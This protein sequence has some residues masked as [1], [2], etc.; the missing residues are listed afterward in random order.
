MV[1]KFLLGMV[2]GGLVVAGGL[3]VASAVAPMRPAND[4]PPVP[5]AEAQVAPAA[6]PADAAV[7]V[8]VAEA[9]AEPAPAA[10]AESVAADLPA[11]QPDVQP[12]IAGAVDGPTAP[13]LAMG[14]GSLST[15]PAT[16][17]SRS[18]SARIS[19]EST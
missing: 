13:M 7:A 9:Q 10:P 8:A 15:R 18:R 1:G 17:T 5:G 4:T 2:S 3:I 11:V 6:E 12:E 16:P 19:R 14:F